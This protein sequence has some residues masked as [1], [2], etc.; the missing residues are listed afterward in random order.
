MFL[1][2]GLGK[3]TIKKLG[4]T[5]EHVCGHCHKPSQRI[6]I[7]VVDWFTIFFLPIFPYLTRYVLVC[8]LCDNAREVNRD[9]LA[10]V[11]NELMP[12]DPADFA[13]NDQAGED[14]DGSIGWPFGDDAE[15][16]SLLNRANR[17]EG[18]TPTQIAY[19]SKME[20]REKELEAQRE[21]EDRETQDSVDTRDA[22][23]ARDEP[24]FDEAETE[25][26]ISKA[27]NRD[28][29]DT[30]KTQD[31]Q[32]EENA[33]PAQSG[34]PEFG[35]AGR[36]DFEARENELNVRQKALEAREKAAEVREK[37]LEAREKAA[38]IREKALEIREMKQS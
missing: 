38:E 22:Q 20:A 12:L 17:Y 19:L 35:D 33:Q 21:K 24:E 10:D 15:K 28:S 25:R 8:P 37:A 14:G 30:R 36:K 32:D 23:D 27:E 7:K 5:R 34:P 11:A 31:A 13:D 16:R 6:L 2:F 3:Q 4:K 26:E 18:K 9:E 29:E 1:L